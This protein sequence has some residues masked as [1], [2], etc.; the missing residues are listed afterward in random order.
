MQGLRGMI[1]V[2]SS[3]VLI[4]A[5]VYAGSS[6][7][8]IVIDK[9]LSLLGA[10]LTSLIVTS[11]SWIQNNPFLQTFLVGS[12]GTTIVYSINTLWRYTWSKVYALFRS[13][14]TINNTDPSYT[15]V[16][17]FITEAFLKDQIGATGN[18]QVSTKK[19]KFTWKDWKKEFSGMSKLEA[20]TL[21]LRPNDD[22]AIHIIKYKGYDITFYRKKGE[23]LTVGYDRT[24]LTKEEVTLSVWGTSNALLIE[25]LQ[26]AV[27]ASIKKEEEDGM[28]IYVMSTTSWSGGWEKALTKKARAVDSVVFDVDHS[29]HII[30]DAR[31]FL[32]S[33]EW[34]SSMGIPFRRG[35]LLYGPP[36]CGKTSFAQVLAGELKLDIC[37][38][39]MS[40]K[41]LSDNSLAETLREAPSKAIILLED[42]DAIFVERSAKS[43]A[44]SSSSDGVSF[45]GLLNAIDGVAAQEGRIFFM[46]TNYI[47]RLDSAL[48]RPGRCDVK[49]EVKRASKLQLE[50]MFLRFFPGKFEQADVFAKRLPSDEVSM[51]QL[52]GHFLKYADSPEDCINGIPELLNQTKPNIIVHTSIYEHLRRVGLEMYT[53]LFEFLGIHDEAGASDVSISDLTELCPLL[54]FDLDGYKRMTNLLKRDDK[55]MKDNYNI[56]DLTSVRESFLAAYPSVYEREHGELA[57]VLRRQNTY[58]SHNDYDNNQSSP[59][60]NPLKLKREFSNFDDHCERYEDQGFDVDINLLMKKYSCNSNSNNNNNVNKSEKDLSM[61]RTDH[62]SPLLLDKLSRKLCEILSH[63]GKS[64][65]SFYQ[66][67]RLVDNFPNRP[68]QCVNAAYTINAPRMADSYIIPQFST[69]QFAKRAAAMEDIFLLER[70]GKDASKLLKFKTKV[71]AL[72]CTNATFFSEIL[73][74]TEQ[75]KFIKNKIMFSYASKPRAIWEFLSFYTKAKLNNSNNELVNNDDAIETI[76][77]DNQNQ[78]ANELPELS[79]SQLEDIAYQFGCKACDINGNGLVSLIEIDKY[80]KSKFPL[81][82]IAAVKNVES[83]LLTLIRPTAPVPIAPPPKTE[84]VYG[85]LKDTEEGSEQLSNTYG[86]AFMKQGLVTE[87]DVRLCELS[88]SVLK[89]TI[90]V[91][92]FGDQCKILRMHR[93]LIES[94]RA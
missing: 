62:I 15:A 90:G 67:K 82:P 48:I 70:V 26:A 14:I 79:R 61:L 85:W 24:P 37:I 43:G 55:F 9:L 51:A 68:I 36:G 66:L 17:D 19:K 54:A 27:L 25:F 45:S 42:V 57:P 18:M 23:T 5:M 8:N 30:A 32:T 20:P 65:V 50:K 72:D 44:G 89:D 33:G 39:N 83:Q 31:K 3:I 53:S 4:T 38:L 88:H 59:L 47:D 49:L 77:D 80:L 73:S 74:I 52:Q 81:S 76:Q 64:T 93:K 58:K 22:S 7:R 46:T 71:D 29:E 91:Q 69:E 34:Y 60:G 41:G 6:G 87:K 78:L 86:M 16:I 10:A 92:I 13:D 40:H 28:N 63:S 84:W 94:T 2:T 75:N 56:A 35:Y 1:L 21:D 12:I 11:A